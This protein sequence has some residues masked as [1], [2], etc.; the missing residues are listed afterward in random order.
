VLEKQQRARKDVSQVKNVL[1]KLREGD[2]VVTRTFEKWDDALF[3][4]TRSIVKLIPI[5]RCLVVASGS[6]Q[7]K[8]EI[9]NRSL[10]SNIEIAL[11]KSIKD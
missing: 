7:R 10:I 5:S 11:L 4:G 2:G 6:L 8:S 9:L 3:H 1:N